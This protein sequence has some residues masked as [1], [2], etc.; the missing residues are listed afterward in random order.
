M[1]AVPTDTANGAPRE[2]AAGNMAGRTFWR[3]VA[4]YMWSSAAA[5]TVTLF[6]VLVGAEFTLYQW[7]YTLTVSCFVIPGY[8]LPD[9]WVLNRHYKPIRA[10]L[11][12]IDGGRRPDPYDV[13]RAIVRALNLPFYS[14]VRVTLVHG[15]GATILL[16]ASLVVG[17]ALFDTG[18]E[19]WQVL[20]FMATIFFF[21]S[22]AHAIFEFFESAKISVPLVERLWQYGR[23]IE[24]KHQK[25]LISIRLKNKLLYLSVFITALPLLFFAVSIVFKVDLLFMELGRDVTVAEMQPLLMWVGGV[26]L[27]CMTGALAMSILTASE[28]SRSAGRLIAAM[29]AVENGDLSREL[30]VTGTDEYADLFRG[31]NLMVANLREEVQI[32]ALSHD[33]AGELNLDV[34]LGRIMKATTDLLDADRSTL[35]LHDAKTNELWSRVAEGLATKEIRFPANSGI[36]GAVFTSRDTANIADAYEDPRFNRA[37]DRTTGY[38]TRTLL[39]MPIVNKAGDCIGVTQVLNKRGGMFTAKDVARLGAFSAQVA[40]ALENAKL[41][42]DVLNQKNYNDSILKSTTDGMITLDAEGVILTANEAA[43][44]I[45]NRDRGQLLRQPAARVFA[46]ANAWVLNHID[47]VRRSGLREIA[48][49]MEI[50]TDVK[51]AASVNLAV[52]PLIDAGENNLGSLIV[53]EDITAERRMKSTMAR[54]MS[55]EVAEQLLA[56]GEASLGGKDQKVSILF[57]DVRNFTTVSEALGAKETVSMLNSYFERMVDVVFQNRGVL[58]KFIGDAIMALF[59]VPF[60]GER[61]ADDAVKVANEMHVALRVLNRERI[62]QGRDPIDI[63]VG[64]STGVVVVGNIGSPKRMEYTVIGDSVNLASRLEGATKFYGAKVLISEYTKREL[65][66]PARLREIDLMRVKGKNE[67]VAIFE[68]M[69]HYTGDSFPHLAQVLGHYADGL[70]RYRDRAWDRATASFEAALKLNPNDKPSR[71]YLDRAAHFR[72]NPPPDDWDGVWVMTS[73]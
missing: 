17:N 11:A 5:V 30:R 10:V 49:E 6:L 1:T 2:I 21:A 33:L 45:L 12:T 53:F 28:V 19:V 70:A 48:V 35:F 65:K 13:S 42:E 3:Y 57:S 43:F 22:P 40:V 50:K 61:D 36:A 46:D 18:F 55:P 47:R 52:N 62:G 31:F 71:L 44:K 20:F 56:E 29:R 72:A 41:F 39:A 73:K 9:I 69:D 58:D 26:V 14:S 54:Y 32:L 8:T 4:I 25:Q 66:Y 15:P 63:G 38:R 16:G 60:N 37:V 27:V 23:R 67:P 64:I 59:G 34:L 7:I 51:S 68:A 24:A